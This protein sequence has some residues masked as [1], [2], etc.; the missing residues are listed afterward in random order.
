MW[1]AWSSPRAKKRRWSTACRERQCVRGW[2][3]TPCHSAKLPTIWPVFTDV[4][5]SEFSRPKRRPRHAGRLTMTP[6]RATPC[7]VRRW[8]PMALGWALVAGLPVQSAAAAPTD[9]ER[10]L[11]GSGS[12]KSADAFPAISVQGGAAFQSS[13][14]PAAFGLAGFEAR[15]AERD[16]SWLRDLRGSDL[17]VRWDGR[18]LRYLDFYRWDARG[19]SLVQRWFRKSGRYAGMIRRAL[20]DQGLSEDLIWVALVESGFDPTIKSWAGAAGLWQLMPEGARAYGLGVDR[21]FD[22][23]LDPE[24]S[25]EVAARYLADLYRRFGAWELALAAYNMGDGGLCNAI[26][27]YNTTDFW[28]LSG[29]EAGVPYETALYVPK[30]LALAVVFHNAAAFGIDMGDLEPEVQFE[31]VIAPPNTQLRTIAAAARVDSRLI[32][33]LNP[34]MRAKRTPP[35]RE[36]AIYAVRVPLG[37]GPLVRD[38]LAKSAGSN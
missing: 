37:K 1:A 38:A 8:F 10:E 32:E 17:S 19:K 11:F 28:E 18:I 29:I 22:E 5:P 12:S 7:F 9:P 2:R 14:S 31:S 34:Q 26:R 30:I 33:E 24:R 36:G 20:R 35:A 25:T 21:N 23:R 4:A 3:P 16:P 27:K 15:A 13:R 6:G